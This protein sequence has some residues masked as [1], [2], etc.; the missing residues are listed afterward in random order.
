MGVCFFFFS[1]FVLSE[2]MKAQGGYVP[3]QYIPLQQEDNEF[4]SNVVDVS[5]PSQHLASRP[6]PVQ[7]SSGI[8]ACCDDMPSCMILFAS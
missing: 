3:P 1:C 5:Q 4:E 6:D 2:R 7:W 8:C